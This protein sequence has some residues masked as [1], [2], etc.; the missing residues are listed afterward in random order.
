VDGY[1]EVVTFTR[2]AR[3]TRMARITS[4]VVPADRYKRPSFLT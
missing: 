2:T 4:G 1:G 3:M